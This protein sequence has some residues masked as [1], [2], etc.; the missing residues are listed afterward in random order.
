M[1]RV[2]PA[3]FVALAALGTALS[4][5]ARAADPALSEQGREVYESYC[6]LCHGPQGDGKG[7]MGIVSRVQRKGFT[8]DIFPRDF[9]A[10]VY[11]FRSTLTGELPTDQDLLHIITEG[12][13]RS[14]MPSHKDVSPEDRQ[15]VVAF[16]KTFSK[17]WTE[18]TPGNPIPLPA[19]PSYVGTP[20]SVSRGKDLYGPQG[21]ACH[22]CH[23]LSG[24][25]DGPSSSTLKDS[26]GD[27]I[28]A[29]DFTSGALKGGS[30]PED[31]YRTFMT[32]LDGTPMP[33]Y[34]ETM[35][36]Q[37]RWDLVSYCLELMKSSPTAAN[38]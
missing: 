13:P 35:D 34:A 17:R 37:Q 8:I 22:T 27:P 10:G 29:F 30:R 33:S 4:P 21:V 2:H 16:I 31:I 3:V 28:L 15:A 5:P 7:L 12:I 18:D 38:K 32:G 36:E 24:K 23:G 25:G 26:W 6:V 20:A 11:K 9:T 14:G 1:L 19:P